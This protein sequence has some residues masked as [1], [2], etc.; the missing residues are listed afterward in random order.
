MDLEI[1]I[2]VEAGY[3]LTAAHACPTCKNAALVTTTVLFLT[4]PTRPVHSACHDCRG[5]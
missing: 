5:S 1:K 4:R 2:D 3:W